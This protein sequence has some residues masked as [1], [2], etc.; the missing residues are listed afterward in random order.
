MAPVK[1]VYLP[2]QAPSKKG[3]RMEER[4]TV[5]QWKTYSKGTAG[6]P[7]FINP[8]I[9]KPGVRAVCGA[10]F[11]DKYFLIIEIW[12]SSNRWPYKTY[13]KT[14]AEKAK[15]ENVA[16]KYRA[17]SGLAEA[18]ICL[19]GFLFID[20]G[21]VPD[22]KWVIREESWSP[23]KLPYYSLPGTEAEVFEQTEPFH[24]FVAFFQGCEIGKYQTAPR[25]CIACEERL[26]RVLLLQETY[27]PP[28]PPI[29]FP[30]ITV[31]DIEK[32]K[33][34]LVRHEPL[35]V[36]MH[37]H[38]IIEYGIDMSKTISKKSVLRKRDD[39]VQIA[40]AKVMK[41]K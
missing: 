22:P 4:C 18:Q 15:G 32:L 38:H 10:T 23:N 5:L 29:P 3:S 1:E 33:K 35:I 13:I 9:I 39:A 37:Q 14:R 6:W 20:L 7:G 25:A 26:N 24:V 28:F 21:N 19:E 31:R 34:E 30:P 12:D 27:P 40:F 2:D 11:R 16:V 8:H 17:C 41:Q 36:P